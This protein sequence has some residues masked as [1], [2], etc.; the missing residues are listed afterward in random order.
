M[1]G[2]AN[3]SIFSDFVVHHHLGVSYGRPFIGTK[4]FSRMW[5]PSGHVYHVVQNLFCLRK[6]RAKYLKTARKIFP[7]PHRIQWHEVLLW[8][9]KAIISYITKFCHIAGSSV[10]AC[11]PA[12]HRSGWPESSYMEHHMISTL[13]RCP[14]CVAPGDQWLW[15]IVRCDPGTLQKQQIFTFNFLNDHAH[16]SEAW[17]SR[18]KVS[19]AFGLA[20]VEWPVYMHPMSW[21]VHCCSAKL[22]EILI[23]EQTLSPSSPMFSLLKT[24]GPRKSEFLRKLWTPQMCIPPTTNKSKRPYQP[25][26]VDQLNNELTFQQSEELREPHWPLEYCERAQTLLGEEICDA[27]LVNPHHFSWIL[28]GGLLHV[29]TCS[30]KWCRLRSL[31]RASQ[32]FHEGP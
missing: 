7:V 20:S 18:Q 9:I 6:P 32:L 11:L 25:G 1:L 10:P 30:E 8:C 3:L 5:Q 16:V 28:S 23:Q 12:P 21:S 27:C 2:I 31:C 22:A 19:T 29:V 17:P 26:W 13:A 14:L 4:S 15:S 24:S